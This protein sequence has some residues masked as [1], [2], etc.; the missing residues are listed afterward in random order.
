MCVMS[1]SYCRGITRR[2]RIRQRSDRLAR[3]LGANAALVSAQKASIRQ[4]MPLILL[5]LRSAVPAG[6]GSD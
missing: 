5:D 1:I 2:V 3:H 4:K 6:G